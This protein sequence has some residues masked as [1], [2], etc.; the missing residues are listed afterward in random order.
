METYAPKIVTIAQMQQAVARVK[1]KYS[2]QL[3][4][5]MSLSGTVRQIHHTGGKVEAADEIFTEIYTEFLKLI[6]A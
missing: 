2:R 3:D 4:G 5:E 1:E 6:Y